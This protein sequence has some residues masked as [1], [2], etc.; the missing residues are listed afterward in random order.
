[1]WC[2]LCGNILCRRRRDC[3]HFRGNSRNGSAISGWYESVASFHAASNAKKGRSLK[4]RCQVC[5][6]LLAPS[7]KYSVQLRRNRDT[8]GIGLLTHDEYP[9]YRKHTY[10]I[11]TVIC[12]NINQQRCC[13]YSFD[14]RIMKQ[15]LRITSRRCYPDSIDVKKTF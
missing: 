8:R 5:A 2:T 9:T 14:Q 3:A 7:H 6:E 12:S 10:R 15:F 13:R 1:M 4:K 11:E